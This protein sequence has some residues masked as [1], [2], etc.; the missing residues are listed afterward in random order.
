[1]LTDSNFL[2]NIVISNEFV[3]N[4][5][6]IEDTENVRIWRQKIHGVFRSKRCIVKR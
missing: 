6:G 2:R 1:M 4:V 3:F 5:S